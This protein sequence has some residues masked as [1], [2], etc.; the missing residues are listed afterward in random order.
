MSDND[1]ALPNGFWSIPGGCPQWIEPRSLFGIFL[2]R[3][4]LEFDRALFDGLALSYDELHAYV[5]ASPAPVSQ[6]IFDHTG[7]AF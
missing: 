4:V 6:K 7:T 3:I 2:R 1:S 5:K